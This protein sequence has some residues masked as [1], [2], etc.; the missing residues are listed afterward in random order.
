M[1]FCCRYRDIFK[2][3]GSKT[4]T[5]SLNNPTITVIKSLTEEQQNAYATA[6]AFKPYN[7]NLKTVEQTISQNN[8]IISGLSNSDNTEVSSSIRVRD[9]N[10]N[11]LKNLKNISPDFEDY[12]YPLQ[13]NSNDKIIFRPMEL[14][15]ESGVVSASGNANFGL[16]YNTD[17]NRRTF[18]SVSNGGSVK[19]GIQGPISD[20]NLVNWQEGRVGPLDA[21]L[22]NSAMGALKDK[23][24]FMGA[25]Q[26]GGEN[27][28]K[29]TETVVNNL[30]S[31]GI[32]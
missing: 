18:K 3:S 12:K 5:Q 15:L 32:Y 16:T 4:N 19:L 9:F 11:E 10:P 6:E 13:E 1:D 30:F 29:N 26:G 28:I 31:T 7:T 21:I 23:S 14:N 27:L 22:Y 20:Q 8:E 24:D 2:I 17:A 25:L